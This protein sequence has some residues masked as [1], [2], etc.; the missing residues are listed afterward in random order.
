MEWDTPHRNLTKKIYYDPGYLRKLFVVALCTLYMQINIEWSLL[1]DTVHERI[2][3]ICAF[4]YI[5]LKYFPKVCQQFF[6]GLH[7]KIKCVFF[8]QMFL[9]TFLSLFHLIFQSIW[10][11]M[12]LEEN[13]LVLRCSSR[14]RYTESNS[15]QE[16]TSVKWNV[17]I[18]CFK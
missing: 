3:V 10:S 9:A 4:L 6:Q 17:I 18:S 2:S 14:E 8:N 11:Q 13:N 1:S 15:Y 5:R 12:E 16:R 7:F